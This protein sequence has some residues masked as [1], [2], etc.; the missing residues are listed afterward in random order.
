[1]FIVSSHLCIFPFH[2]YPDTNSLFA[3]KRFEVTLYSRELTVYV[4]VWKCL[5][6]FPA[7]S[8]LLFFYMTSSLKVM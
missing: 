3:R 2:L 7:N 5:T 1:M 6:L 8:S 4:H